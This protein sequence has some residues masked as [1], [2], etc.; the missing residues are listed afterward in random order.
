M[1]YFITPVISVLLGSL[2]LNMPSIEMN[3]FFGFRTKTSSVNQMTW[4]YCNKLCG[5]FLVSVG[6]IF[7]FVL[8]F[9]GKLDDKFMFGLTKGE[10]L[11]I[12]FMLIVILSI[13]TINSLCKK[14]FPQFYN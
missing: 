4:D 7:T 13:P 14:K 8:I 2:I 3:S 10:S 5:K 6:T 12:L 9:I 1:S 11:N